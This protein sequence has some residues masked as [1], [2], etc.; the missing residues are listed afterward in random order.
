MSL[1]RLEPTIQQHKV[2]QKI[3]YMRSWSVSRRAYSSS[4]WSRTFFIV[5]ATHLRQL[6]CS[7]STDEGS[8]IQEKSQSCCHHHLGHYRHVLFTPPCGATCTHSPG[9]G[10]IHSYT[11]RPPAETDSASNVTVRS[12]LIP[13]WASRRLT[14]KARPAR[15]PLAEVRLSRWCSI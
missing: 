1:I 12:T 7:R 3:A 9:D 11:V 4:S 13:S 15:G 8:L 10:T 14:L 6:G 5:Y 2:D